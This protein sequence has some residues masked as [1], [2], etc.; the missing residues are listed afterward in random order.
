MENVTKRTEYIPTSG[1]Y[2]ELAIRLAVLGLLLYWTFELVRPF[3]TIIV[4]AS[5]I[6]VALYPAFVWLAGKLGGREHLAAFLLTAFS[7][8]V[9]VGPVTW[10]GIDAVDSSKALFERVDWEKL[11]LPPPPSSVKSWPV[12]GDEIFAVWTM[13]AENTRVIAVKVYPYLKPWGATALSTATTAAIGI[14]KFLIAIILSGFLFVPAPSLINGIKRLVARLNPERG[15]RFV[16][17][18][19]STIRSVSRGVIG[20]AV[21]QA[22]LAGIGLYIAGIH[23]AGIIT[24]LALILGII[25]IGCSVVL[26]PV[27]IWAWFIM[28][29]VSALIFTL[30]MVPVSLVDNL[31]RPLVLGRGLQTP[32][33]VIFIGVL[34]GTIA[35]GITGLFLGPIVLAVIWELAVAWIYQDSQDIVPL[36]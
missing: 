1:S 20:I 15:E 33:L 27:T 4:W 22:G 17:L 31:L 6:A 28:E 18:A 3:L 10:I 19:G 7:F 29:P 8:L 5:I 34:G 35:Y 21:L 23:G 36:G 24:L 9:A 30:Y 16:A 26:I 13:A 11:S 12:F 2:F 32:M 14:I 25:Q